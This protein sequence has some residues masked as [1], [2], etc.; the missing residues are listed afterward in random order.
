MKTTLAVLLA[1]G[2]AP[3]SARVVAVP[4][5]AMPRVAVPAVMAPLA[6]MPRASA[7]GSPLTASP[8]LGL[9]APNLAP[10]FSPLPAP[11]ALR[12]AAARPAMLPAAPAAPADAPTAKGSLEGASA[13]LQ[14]PHADQRGV[15][16]KVFDAAVAAPNDSALPGGLGFRAPDGHENARIGSAVGLLSR[17]PIGRDIYAKAYNDYGSRLQVLVDDAPGASYDARLNWQ[18]GAPVLSLTRD[19]LNRGSDAAVAALL[20]REMSHL[21]YKDFPDSAERSWMAHSVMVRTFA[22]ITGSGP[23]WWDYTSDLARD[24]RHLMSAFY[25]SWADAMRR[26]H[27]PRYGDFFRWLRSGSESKSGPNAALSLRDLYD[28]G[29]LGWNQYRQMDSY[30]TGL[31]SSERRWLNDRR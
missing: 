1:L 27:D 8:A 12:D 23:R 14:A 13:A 18:N 19:L 15:S 16:A 21:Y 28:R 2:A 6:A 24:G 30:F 5:A 7:A 31:V 11:P 25:A 9:V 26:H 29:L 22:E 20:V 4:R 3:A 17:T 10:S